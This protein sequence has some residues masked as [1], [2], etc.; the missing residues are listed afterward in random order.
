VPSVINGLYGLLDDRRDVYFDE[1]GLIKVAKG[2][3]IFATRNVG[4]RYTGTMPSDISL[5]D[6]FN[7]TMEVDFLPPDKEVKILMDRTG[8]DLESADLL[9]KFASI[10]REKAASE[11]S[12]L[13]STISTRALLNCASMFNE[14][15]LQSLDYTILPTY[16]NDGN[17]DSERSQIK[18]IRN[19][20]FGQQ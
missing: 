9:V 10:I 18:L 7:I 20:V 14:L 13:R 17:N 6:R 2:V 19:M 16:S 15:G 4:L 5:L 12:N 3:T 8:I 11:N 1:V